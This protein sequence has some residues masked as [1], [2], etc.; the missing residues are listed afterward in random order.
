MMNEPNTGDLIYLVTVK[1][2]HDAAAMS[3]GITQTF[4]EAVD[5]WASIDPVGNAIYFGTKQVGE[6][7]THRIITHYTDAINDRKITAEHV[8]EYDNQRYRVRRASNLN[9]QRIWVMLEVELLGDI[10]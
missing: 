7:V 8:V 2:W 3:G 10:A 9:G 5:A 6:D 4:D 1:K